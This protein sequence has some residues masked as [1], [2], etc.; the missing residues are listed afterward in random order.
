VTDAPKQ[1]AVSEANLRRGGHNN[2]FKEVNTFKRKRGNQKNKERS[3]QKQLKKSYNYLH[4]IAP[5][6]GYI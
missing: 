1:S 2:T 5:D 4:A 3:D 6:V